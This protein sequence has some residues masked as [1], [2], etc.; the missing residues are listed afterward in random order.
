MFLNQ[1]WPLKEML[2]ICRREDLG[3][4]AIT[5]PQIR[6]IEI[7]SDIGQALNEGV[8][9]SRGE[10]LV[11]FDDDDWQSAERISL[12]VGHLQGTGRA[13]V[14]LASILLYAEGEDH[15]WRVYDRLQ[16]SAGAALAF[17]REFAMAHPFR[18]G[19][20]VADDTHFVADAIKEDEYSGITGFDILVMSLH[21]NHDSGRQNMELKCGREAL[22]MS[23]N[24][25][26]VP[27]EKFRHIID[28]TLAPVDDPEACPTCGVKGFECTGQGDQM[29]NFICGNGCQE[30]Y[31]TVEREEVAA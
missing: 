21:G 1:D 22:E 24:W 3:D 12:Q 26:L 29:R 13:V 16:H 6:F 9:Q 30:T 8:K 20:G 28:G 17:T 11:R 18:E 19:R 2:V 4:I 27:L 10:V 31:W 25:K 14:G 7:D 23:D 15:G 5:D